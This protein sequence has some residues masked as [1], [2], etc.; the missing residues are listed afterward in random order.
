MAETM[1]AVRMI[2]DFDLEKG[3]PA[4]VGLMQVP[5]P[6]LVS[7]EDVLI[8]IAYSS[9][10]GSDPNILR[11]AFP[12]ARAPRP[13]GH[14][15]SG[16][17]E[18]LGPK[19]AASKG[20]KAGDRVTGDFIFPCH[21]CE[22]CQRG[23][24]Q[25]CTNRYINGSGQAEYI[26]WR[27]GQVYKVPD[28]LSLKQ[29]ALA[30]PFN[31]SFHAVE[32]ADMKAGNS[33]AVMGAGGIGLMVTAVAARCGASSITVFEPVE[34]K[35][36]LAKKLGADYV[37]D[38]INEDPV[39]RAMEITGGFGFNAI[40][41]SSGNS[42][43]AITA[44]KTAAKQAHIVYMSM[45]KSDFD[46]PLNLFQYCY[47]NELRIQGMYLAQGSFKR[48]LSMLG[49][50]NLEPLI[51]KLYKLEDC[52]TAYEDQVSGKYAKLMFEVCPEY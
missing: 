33:V 35:R 41:E 27:E 2:T 5:K 21:S 26:V 31:I 3:I 50:M 8:K 12:D 7:G 44:L 36:E 38:P 1:K 22:Y 4:K 52:V 25:F 51:S 17:I 10:C 15:L 29:A 16:T 34:A 40:L 13:M 14:E 19:A 48:S 45:Y 24:P 6:E 32:I 43:S 9:I 37:I 23:M 42:A 28:S 30:E 18:A 49:K 11:G 46:L 47:H 20:L 39:E